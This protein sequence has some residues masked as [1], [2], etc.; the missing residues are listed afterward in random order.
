M[1]K[2]D[3]KNRIDDCLVRSIINISKDPTITSKAE[4][5]RYLIFHFLTDDYWDICNDNDEVQ[6]E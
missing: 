5:I 3:L 4:Q 6:S 1:T 2:G